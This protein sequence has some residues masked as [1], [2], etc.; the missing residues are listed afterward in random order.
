MAADLPPSSSVTRTQ[1]T[2]A[3]PRDL[4]ARGS[5]T[6]EGDL[7]DIRMRD[8]CLPRFQPTGHDVQHARRQARPA[9]STRTQASRA[10]SRA[11][12]RTTAQPAASAGAVFT[13]ASACGWFHG[14]IAPD[15]PHRLPPHQGAAR[16]EG[17]AALLPL[18]TPREP[19][20][21]AQDP[22]WAVDIST[23]RHG[24]GHAVLTGDQAGQ[25]LGARA[26]G[27]GEP[28]HHLGSFRRG[29]GGPR[30]PRSFEGAPGGGHRA[31]DVP[32]ARD[33]DAPDGFLGRG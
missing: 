20:V 3:D 11:G 2:T 31:V 10:V 25:L 29:G 33:G 6:G 12:L 19:G 4:A 9:V 26:Q 13:I 32:G 14:A 16:G 27:V 8:Q 5:G 22:D 30:R 18:H 28:L 24:Y 21:V 23:G 1:E 15:D 7:V 17:G